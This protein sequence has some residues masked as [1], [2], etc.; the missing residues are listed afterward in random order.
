MQ[1]LGEISDFK[2]R[3]NLILQGFDPISAVGFTQ[4][5]NFILRNK[6]ISIGAKVVYAALLSYAW[7]KDC[8]FPGQE[9]LADDLGISKRSV[10]TFLQDLEKAGYLEKL[11]RGLGKT[12]AYILHCQVKKRK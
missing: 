4:V 3:Q 8:C 5:P 10:I 2:E 7:N 12:N 1:R 9:A 6:S 11:R